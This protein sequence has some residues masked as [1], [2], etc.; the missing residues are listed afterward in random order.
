M[1]GLE[2]SYQDLKCKLVI[3]VA[4]GKILGNI[5]DIIFT[6]LNGKILGF[7]VPGAKKSFWKSCDNIFIPYSQVCK[8]GVDVILVELFVD[9]SP[10]CPCPPKNK[11]NKAINIL[12]NEQNNEE[13]EDLSKI[14]VIDPKIYPK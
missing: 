5:I 11:L 3:N 1:Q 12:H 14:E 9:S 6:P 8:I 7:L 4:D 10:C 2:I 13:N